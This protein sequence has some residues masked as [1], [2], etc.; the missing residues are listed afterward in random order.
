MISE[1]ERLR[2]SW[3]GTCATRDMVTCLP[4][5][6]R[7]S[8]LWFKELPLMCEVVPVGFVAVYELQHGPDVNRSARPGKR[9][10]AAFL[11]FAVNAGRMMRGVN[12]FSD[13]RI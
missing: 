9:L 6:L 2:R 11:D 10:L 13:R 7:S 1:W 5:F 12:R 3:Q 8:T 4:R